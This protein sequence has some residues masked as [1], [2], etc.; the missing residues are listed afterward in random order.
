[1]LLL[2]VIFIATTIYLMLKRKISN[3]GMYNSKTSTEENKDTESNIYKCTNTNAAYKQRA[4]ANNETEVTYDTINPV[5]GTTELQGSTEN[6]DSAKL[7]MEQNV[8]YESSTAAAQ[9]SL[10]SNIAYYKSGK[11]LE[12]IDQDCDDQYDYCNVRSQPFCDHSSY[13]VIW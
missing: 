11:S 9:I 13:A 6:R 3:T 2:L 1:M 12:E 7:N 4:T 8:A 5:E 10:R